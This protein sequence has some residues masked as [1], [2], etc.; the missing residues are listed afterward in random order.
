MLISEHSNIIEDTRM[1]CKCFCC[2]DKISS[3]RNENDDFD[4][5]TSV[6]ILFYGDNITDDQ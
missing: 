1:T 2:K 3:V 6:D 4:D 5:E